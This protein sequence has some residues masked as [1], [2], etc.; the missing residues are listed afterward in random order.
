MMPTDTQGALYLKVEWD[1][2]SA[3]LGN[4]AVDFNDTEFAA[5][6]RS[7]YGGK[8]DYQSV[9]NNPYGDARTKIV[10]YHAQIQQLPSHNE[11]LA[12]GGSLY[13]LKYRNVIQG[14]DT[15]TI[16]V[17]DQTTGLVMASQTMVNGA[18]YEL[19]NSQGRILF[20]QPVAMIAQSESIISNSLIT[21]NPIYVVVDY[22]YEVAGLQTAGQPGCP[23]R[24]GGRRQC[25]LG[26]HLCS[27]QSKWPELYPSRDRCHP[28]CD[29]VMPPSRLNMP[30]PT[31]RKQ[32]HYVSTDGGITFTSMAIANSAS[33][34]AYGI[35]GDARL[36][37]NIGLKSY[38][39]WIGN[40]FAT[41]DST[42][43]QGKEMMGLSMTFDM[44][45]VTRITASEDI[46]RLMARAAICR[47]SA[48]VGASETDTT[49]VQ[50]V[51]TAERLT[52]TG[53]FQLTE[54]KS[55]VN[56]IESTTN[57]RG[58]TIGGQAQYDLTDRVKLTLGQ[59]VDVENKNNTATTLGVAAR[60]T[61]H[62]TLNAQEVFSQQGT[63]T[64]V[65]VTNQLNKRIAL[66]TDYTLDEFKY[67]GS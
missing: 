45:P 1:K 39:K 16:Q 30:K 47:P 10:V 36:F 9:S 53:Q 2:S 17:R 65:G 22:Q 28:A 57:Q 26:R 48:Q 6:S 55:V 58:A 24:P 40:D 34:K 54:T 29:Q 56:G 67:R 64:T 19:D 49:M 37:D 12:T 5:F 11:F 32:D 4:Y 44:T 27:G 18:D 15:V 25:G 33:G 35:K 13:F 43:Q 3:I 42:S 21:G 63:A 38:Y 41:P 8:I 46:Q 14:S 23:C 62:T 20:W 59:Q 52:L 66:T 60:V 7:Y 51:H 50:I 61:D 31:H